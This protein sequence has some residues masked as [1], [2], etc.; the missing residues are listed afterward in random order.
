MNK[1]NLK[2]PINVAILGE[3]AKGGRNIKQ[4]VDDLGYTNNPSVIRNRIDRLAKNGII[5]KTQ[6]GLITE[7]S[8]NVVYQNVVSLVSSTKAC[9]IKP[10]IRDKRL[11]KL[12]LFYP[13]KYPLQQGEQERLF[14][15]QVEIPA[16]LTELN[17]N[18]QLTLK[19]GITIRITSKGMLCYAP[20]LYYKEGQ[21]SIVAE[22]RAKDI[23]DKYALQYEQKLN[24]MGLSFRLLRVKNDVLYSTISSQEIADEKHPATAVLPEDSDKIVLARSPIDNKERLIIDSSKKTFAELETTHSKSA[25]VDMDTIDSQFNGVLDG[26]INLWDINSMKELQVGFA[27]NLRSHL[28]AIKEL[29]IAAKKQQEVADK[30]LK[31]FAEHEGK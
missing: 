7:L 31:W 15:E 21:P 23:L 30:Q 9:Y 29:T 2:N 27:E 24:E 20:E 3:I 14:K 13:F 19:V 25:D 12:G 26:K 11:H 4:V 8:L 18:Q 5:T 17:N 1:A 22:D 16:K 6:K 10:A 28:D